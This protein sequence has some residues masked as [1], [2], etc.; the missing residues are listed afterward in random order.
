[1]QEMKAAFTQLAQTFDERTFGFADAVVIS[2]IDARQLRNGL[3][4]GNLRVGTKLPSVDRWVFSTRECLHL[5]VVGELTSRVWVPVGQA[6]A[7]AA[8]IAQSFEVW[9]DKAFESWVQLPAKGD[10]EAIFELIV[11]GD[12]EGPQILI[13]QRGGDWGFYHLNGSYQEVHIRLPVA[14]LL[15]RLFSAIGLVAAERAARDE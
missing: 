10:I 5:M 3:D 14:G 6:S 7:V 4:R 9:A 8:E 12:Q 2:G 15:Q 13:H 1:V 11:Y